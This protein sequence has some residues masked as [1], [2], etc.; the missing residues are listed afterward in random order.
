[1][2]QTQQKI[3]RKFYY[4]VLPVAHLQD[5]PKGVKLMNEN[6]VLWLDENGQ[7]AAAIDRCCHRTAKLSKGTVREGSVVCP[8]HGWA[9]NRTGK[10]TYFPQSELEDPPKVYKIAGYHCEE[11]Y[12]YVWVALEDPVTGIPEF[13]YADDASF[14]QVDQFYEVIHCAAFRLMEN[15]FDAA[16]VAFV[17]QNTFGDI[18]NPIPPKMDIT[19]A[20]WGFETYHEAPVTNKLNQQVKTINVEEDETVRKAYGRW[21]MPFIRQNTIQYPT[22]LIHSIITCATPIDDKTCQLV[23][24]ALRNDTEA[25]VPAERVIAFDRAVVDEDMDVLETT[26]YNVS[27]D[28]RRKVENHMLSDKPGIVMRQMMLDLFAEYGEEEVI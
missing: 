7:P 10:C 14:R 8:Y 3:F 15:S 13:K 1:M 5:G 4:P 12:G 28:V 6:I 11:R 20:E 26:E 24:F 21:Y 16:H 27:L 25:D 17:H 22:G 19:P 2:L 23:Q 9:F 18:N